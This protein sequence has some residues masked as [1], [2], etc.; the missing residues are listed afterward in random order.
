MYE[1]HWNLTKSPFKNTPDLDFFY[2]SPQHEEAITRMFY[3]LV[4]GRGAMLLTGEC[5]CGKT[6]ISRLFYRELRNRRDKY[7]LVL[8]DNPNLNHQELLREVLFQLGIKTNHTDK[9]ILLQQLSAFLFENYNGGKKTVILVD[10]VQQIQSKATLEELRLL[11]NHHQDHDYLLTLFLLGQ[12]EFNETVRQFPQL[13]QRISTRFNLV[14]FS[15]IDVEDY[16]VYRLKNAGSKQII[17]KKD[18]IKA[19]FD[20]SRGIPRVINHLCDSALLLASCQSKDSIDKDLIMH[21]V[22]NESLLV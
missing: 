2:F 22:K 8:I 7:T 17:F 11:L 20:A 3:T 18:A 5:G 6:L 14:P 9:S 13:D 4:E 12:P 19:L 16:I 21:V 15:Q 10:E 1:K